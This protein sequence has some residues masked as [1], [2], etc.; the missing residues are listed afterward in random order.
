MAQGKYDRLL[1]FGR[2]TW[3]PRE[4]VLDQSAGGVVAVVDAVAST[5]FDASRTV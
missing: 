4:L 3:R 1:D 5:L 2:T